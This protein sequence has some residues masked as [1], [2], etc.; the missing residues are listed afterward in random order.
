MMGVNLMIYITPQIIAYCLPGSE[1]GVRQ[2]P[3]ARK[4][5]PCYPS[6]VAH[7]QLETDHPGV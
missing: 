2:S 3:V 6:V 4:K 7:W 5:Y 1:Y